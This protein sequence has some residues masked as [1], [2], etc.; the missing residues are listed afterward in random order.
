MV[1]AIGSDLDGGY[2]SVVRER[3][4]DTLDGLARIDDDI[5]DLFAA[6]SS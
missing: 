1:A 5:R 6:L 2:G 3:I 4:A